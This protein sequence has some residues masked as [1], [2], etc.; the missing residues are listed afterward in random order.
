MNLF[1]EQQ[2]SKT[3]KDNYMPYA[4]SV[5]ISRAI[6]EIDGLKPSHRKLLYTMYQMKLLTGDRTKSSNIV[7]QTMRLNPH[8][9]QTIYATMVRLTK[10]NGALL[11]P[12]VDSKGN[13]GKQYSRDMAYAAPRYTEAK[14]D[15]FAA[16]LF[17][18]IDKDTVDFVDNYDGTA[19][20]PTLLP[21]TFPNII[22]NPNLG[23]AV[24]MSSNICSFNLTEVC[25]TTIALIKNP[26]HNLMKTLKAPDFSTG[27]QLIYK[28]DELEKIYETGNGNLK[29]RA[30]YHYDKKNHCIE[31]TEIPYTTTAEAIIDK[32]AELV[33]QNKCKEISDVRDE[34]DLKGLKITI[35]IKR[36]AD[37]D[38]LMA[39]LFKQTPLEDNF[40]CNFNI[41]IGSTPK[42][43]GIREILEEWTAF[44]VGCIKR[45][46]YFDI[47]KIK[48]KLHLLYGLREILLDIDKAIAI[49][50]HTE[51]EREVVP[52]LM[53]GFAIDQIQ[54]EYIAEIKLRNLNRE[55]ILK[56][57][58]ET[59]ELEQQLKDL[60]ETLGS[61]DKI[62]AIICDQLTE[63][64]K[65]Y[66]QP[67]RTELISEDQIT[68]FAQEETID[69]YAVKV[70]LT[71]ES[72]FKKISL[73]SLRS[74]GEQKLK[75][76]DKISR[77][78][79]TT[80][81]AEILFFS[82]R[83]NVYKAKLY[84]L[85]DG[86]AA[87]LGD[88]L[89]NLLQM[90]EGERIVDM[91]VT[92]DYSGFILFA[93]ASGKMARVPLKAY[94]TKTN[95]KRL[96][97]AYSAASP[98]VKMIFFT[99]EMELAAISNTGKILVFDTKSV[100]QKSTRD[101]QGVSVLLSKKGS[102]LT[103][104]RPADSLKL[105]DVQYYKTKNIP[106]LGCFLRKGDSLEE[107]ISFL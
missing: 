31:I 57:T 29:I 99:E 56:R 14:L 3:L 80:N 69:D 5:I 47:Q 88:Y 62:N 77:V 94:E 65:K 32:I 78:I 103:D 82:D 75:E 27:G 2:I 60:E 21:V 52:N 36:S 100:S 106:A 95:R 104:L 7:G 19:K 93:F 25:K 22:V 92:E 61:Q 59:D 51:A 63:I 54:A 48:E 73:V 55:Y 44:R 39:R 41:L 81:R 35:D 79:E 8:G 50:R 66:G 64:S 102:L 98:L 23:I 67:R 70:F 30:K 84:D 91:V 20:E 12:F 13:F 71:R 11:H 28:P 68:E 4:M 76:D 101:S 18:D 83:Q 97:N 34:T 33:K 105:K 72:Y 45:R 46:L 85:P 37:P 40:N 1:S 15:K 43:C 17:A 96:T 58:K 53:R 89:P 16:E 90:E 10:S 24:G 49:I 9:D 107:Q 42:V 86:K 38:G 26:K 87:N 6:P 74:S